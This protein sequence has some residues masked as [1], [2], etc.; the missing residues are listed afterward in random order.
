MNEDEKAANYVKR[1]NNCD[2]LGILHTNIGFAQTCEGPIDNVDSFMVPTN[3][4]NGNIYK[5]LAH[6]TKISNDKAQATLV[7]Q[8]LNDAIKCVYGAAKR[9][10]SDATWSVE[11]QWVKVVEKNLRKI[12][13]NMKTI[14][15]IH[16]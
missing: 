10:C 14:N 8:R 9:A 1:V 16:I 5:S 2:D 13:K 7:H 12:F 6:N 11:T 4:N 15:D 3:A